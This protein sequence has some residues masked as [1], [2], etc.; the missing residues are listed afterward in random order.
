MLVH[1]STTGEPFGQVIAE[2]MAAGKPVVA[3]RGGP[4]P[5]IVQEGVTGLLVPVGDAPGMA[6]AIMQLLSEPDRAQ[7]MGKLDGVARV[8]FSP[9]DMLCEV[10]KRSMMISYNKKN[11]KQS[12]VSLLCAGEPY[13]EFAV[14]K[15]QGSEMWNQIC[16]RQ[17]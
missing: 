1:A 5:E 12:S 15:S 2:G 7:Q 10:S 4:V 6:E 11:Q 17:K 13:V 9:S 16:R 3:T 14:S 8:N